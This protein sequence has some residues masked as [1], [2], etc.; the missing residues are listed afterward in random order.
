[1]C[2]LLC[3]NPIMSQWLPQS[4]DVGCRKALTLK[5]LLAADLLETV[6]HLEAQGALTSLRVAAPA[7]GSVRIMWCEEL[8]LVP[9]TQTRF[10]RVSV[11]HRNKPFE[12]LAHAWSRFLLWLGCR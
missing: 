10:C 12:L 4:V 3:A 11:Q 6:D 8:I 5:P 7:G 2:W 9:R 1:M